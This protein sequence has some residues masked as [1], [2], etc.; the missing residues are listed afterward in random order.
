M[1]RSL[2]AFVA[3]LCVAGALW[4]LAVAIVRRGRLP[5][6]TIWLVLGVAVAMR[7][8]TL[9]APPVLS[10]DLYR[11][12]WDGRVQL[13][14]INPYR[15]LPVAD[16]LAFL[17]DDAV[18]PHINRADYAHTVY[19]PAAQVIFALAAVVTPGVFGMK[20]MI[21]AFD[22]L[23][24]V[25]LIAAAAHG[26]TRSGGTADLCLAAAAG[27][28]VRR[29]CAHRWRGCRPARAGVAGRGARAFDLDRHR[30]GRGDA[31]EVPAGGGAAGVLAAA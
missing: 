21:A 7:L 16:E 3:S 28:G 2:A 12:V 13:A 9:T 5:P 18:Y 8:L 10:S 22:A 27:L 15:Y 26:R 25:A 31:D 19:P 14:G 20:V 1:K 29:Q 23:A 11:Y 30:A 4:L 17:R 24:I 6:R